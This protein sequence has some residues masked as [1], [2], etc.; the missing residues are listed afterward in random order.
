MT[1]SVCRRKFMDY[2]LRQGVFCFHGMDEMGLPGVEGLSL[3]I[4]PGND[5]HMLPALV[6][7]CMNTLRSLRLNCRS[8]KLN[9]YKLISAIDLCNFTALEMLTLIFWNGHGMSSPLAF[10][11]IRQLKNTAPTKIWCLVIYLWMAVLEKPHCWKEVEQELTPEAM[12]W[13]L[14]PQL[15]DR[16][17]HLRME[18]VQCTLW[19]EALAD[20]YAKE[21]KWLCIKRMLEASLECIRHRGVQVEADVNI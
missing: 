7:G 18:S 8:E 3:E 5:M 14:L 9:D 4:M 11:L 12:Q 2:F 10:N 13:S 19:L 16:A 20:V 1:S 17:V 15:L 21:V 6:W